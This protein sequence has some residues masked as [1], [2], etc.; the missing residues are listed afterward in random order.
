MLSFITSYWI[1]YPYFFK[2]DIKFNK[3]LLGKHFWRLMANEGSLVGRIFKSRYYPRC[4][5]MEAGPGYQP[6]YAWGSILSAKEIVQNGARW[7]IGNGRP[8]GIWGD[9]WLPKQTSFRVLSLNRVLDPTDK[10]EELIDNNT[11]QWNRELVFQCLN[12]YEVLH[13]LN[14]HV[15]EAT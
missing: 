2:G 5:F 3:T 10:V 14:I 1:N 13:V 12:N 6:S 8:V 7:Q 11:K 4:S 9:R 15:F